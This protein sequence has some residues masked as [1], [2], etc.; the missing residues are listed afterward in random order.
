[1]ETFKSNEINLIIGTLDKLFTLQHRYI[2]ATDHSGQ[3]TEL[4]TS[5]ILS[6][7]Y[8]IS[9][10]HNDD[11]NNYSSGSYFHFIVCLDV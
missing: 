1:M 9:V 8:K 5:I 10:R 6:D 3:I 7:A 4:C 2:H 11:N